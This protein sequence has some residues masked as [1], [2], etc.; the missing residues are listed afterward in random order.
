MIIFHFSTVLPSVNWPLKG[1]REHASHSER[2]ARMRNLTP[3]ARCR[4]RAN[5][6]AAEDRRLWDLRGNIAQR[7]GRSQNVTVAS[8]EQ[9][10][11]PASQTLYV[12]LPWPR[13]PIRS[14]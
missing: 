14:V 9:V 13:P 10:W 11:V 7:F 5:R 2:S 6:L 8:F 3:Y 1:M 4:R 12:K